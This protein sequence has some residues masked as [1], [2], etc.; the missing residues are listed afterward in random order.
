MNANN[1][2]PPSE[3]LQVHRLMNFSLI[4]VPRWERSLGYHTKVSRKDEAFLEKLDTILIAKT[5]SFLYHFEV[6]M[7][8]LRTVHFTDVTAHIYCL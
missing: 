5:T 6:N 8:R 1:C 7:E 2:I 4:V 3:N